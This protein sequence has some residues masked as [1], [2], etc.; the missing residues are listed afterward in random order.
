[1]NKQPGAQEFKLF[2]TGCC[3]CG[4]TGGGFA[5]RLADCRDNPGMIACLAC[6]GNHGRD[7]GELDAEIT[8][9]KASPPAESRAEMPEDVAETSVADAAVEVRSGDETRVAPSGGDS[10]QSKAVVEACIAWQEDDGTCHFCGFG[11]NGLHSTPL[12]DTDCPLVANGFITREGKRIV[13][14][15]QP[16]RI[17]ALSTSASP[18]DRLAARKQR[19]RA[20]LFRDMSR[21]VRTWRDP[22]TGE[23]VSFWGKK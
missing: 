7:H 18:I 6:Y 22:M 19:Q 2:E 23:R 14:T 9:R 11:L 1:M 3:L 12:H 4:A 21:D 20:E 16:D 17:A 13:A 5:G 10:G 8:R 15:Q